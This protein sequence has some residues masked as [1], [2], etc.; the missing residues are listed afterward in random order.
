[1][2]PSDQPPK[3][4]GDGDDFDE[5]E[6]SVAS[7]LL[8]VKRGE[9]SLSYRQAKRFWKRYSANGA[10]GWCIGLRG[11]PSNRKTDGVRR[12]TEISSC[13]EEKYFGCRFAANIFMQKTRKALRGD[14]QSMAQASGQMSTTTTEGQPIGPGGGNWSGVVSG[15]TG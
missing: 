3:E 6:G 15:A 1:M 11:K 13:C 4:A 7:R 9:M 8:Q 14:V 5:C 12:Y 10:S 2:C